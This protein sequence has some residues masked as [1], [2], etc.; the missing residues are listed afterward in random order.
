[1]SKTKTNTQPVV[2]TVERYDVF[3]V[4]PFKSRDDKDA[5]EWVRIGV[6]VPHKEKPGFNIQLIALPTDGKLVLLP[7]EAK[8][9]KPE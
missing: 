4:R 7:H 1:M 9:D 8:D 6:A 2:N 3:A 5:N